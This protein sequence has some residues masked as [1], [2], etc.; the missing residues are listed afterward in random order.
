MPSET[1]RLSEHNPAKSA[2]AS[3]VKPG[4]LLPCIAFDDRRK[5]E[6]FERY[7]ASGSGH[8]VAALGRRRAT[9]VGSLRPLEAVSAA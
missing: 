9:G 7:R 3:K 2:H 8:A 5:A 6:A 1:F 4:G